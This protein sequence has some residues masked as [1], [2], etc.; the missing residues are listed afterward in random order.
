MAA[1]IRP[2]RM[3]RGTPELATRL[4]RSKTMTV[5]VA[6]TL[7]RAMVEVAMVVNSAQMIITVANNLTRTMAEEA[8]VVNNAQMT[9]TVENALKRVMAEE[10]VVNDSQIILIPLAAMVHNAVTTTLLTV[11]VVWAARDLHMEVRNTTTTAGT[12]ARNDKT[13]LTTTAI[14]VVPT[15]DMDKLVS[16]HRPEDT[17]HPMVNLTNQATEAAT[18]AGT[19][20]TTAKNPSAA[21]MTQFWRGLPTARLGTT[22]VISPPNP[23]MGKGT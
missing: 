14:P 12:A 19:M 3:A 21:T 23:A 10:A 16:E 2:I 11:A 22:T 8:M 6:K 15:E 18:M 7:T 20:T 17:T 4:R 13:T 5:T 9:I 1:L